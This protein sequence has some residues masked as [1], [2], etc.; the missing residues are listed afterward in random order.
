MEEYDYAAME[1]GFAD[2]DDDEEE[3]EEEDGREESI[4]LNMVQAY[5]WPGTMAR[6]A[7]H[8]EGMEKKYCSFLPVGYII[9]VS[10]FFVYDSHH[11]YYI[12]G[13]VSRNNITHYE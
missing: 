6:I 9:L 4:L 11:K 5:D 12:G 8:P 2:D 13:H 7:S 1:V 10:L 3:E